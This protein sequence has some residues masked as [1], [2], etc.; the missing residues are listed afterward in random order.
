MKPI[1]V[2]VVIGNETKRYDFPK[3][4]V[5]ALETFLKCHTRKELGSEVETPVFANGFQWLESK[6]QLALE[7]LDLYKPV[8][9]PMPEE[10][11]KKE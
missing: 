10:E 6:L 4:F 11:L 9:E 2:I 1:S 3:E 5:Q 7:E 8:P